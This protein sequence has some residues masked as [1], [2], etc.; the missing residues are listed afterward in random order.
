MHVYNTAYAVN[1][2]MMITFTHISDYS[3]PA[4]ELYA[5]LYFEELLWITFNF[6]YKSNYNCRLYIPLELEPEQD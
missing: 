4:S 1:N 3:Y 5:S 6:L 2:K